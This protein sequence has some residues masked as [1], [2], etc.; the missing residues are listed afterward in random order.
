MGLFEI[1]YRLCI[2][3]FEKLV[4]LNNALD[5]IASTHEGAP[6]RIR[7]CEHCGR[8]QTIGPGVRE[9]VVS[10]LTSELQYDDQTAKNVYESRI[11]LAHARSELSED[12]LRKYS[13]QSILVATA[14]RA[15]LESRLSVKLPSMPRH[16]PFDPH[17]A[18]LDITY[19][20]GQPQEE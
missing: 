9:R 14:V 8:E 11:D 3:S 15:G 20:E 7:R 10:F 12:D 5:L 17:S 2:C 13:A 16:P 4:A 18:L 19:T 6:H 1:I